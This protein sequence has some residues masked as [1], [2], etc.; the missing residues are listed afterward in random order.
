MLYDYEKTSQ[1]RHL[2]MKISTGKNM[3]EGIQFKKVVTAPEDKD[4]LIWFEMFK[5]PGSVG[6]LNE[7]GDPLIISS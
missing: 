4:L 3:Y 1:V 2:G 5:A 6:I 7:E